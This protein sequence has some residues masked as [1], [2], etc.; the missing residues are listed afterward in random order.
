MTLP[1]G[2]VIVT[3]MLVGSVKHAWFEIYT[4]C[5]EK[6][7]NSLIGA[8]WSPEDAAKLTIDAME[9]TNDEASYFKNKLKFLE[10][11]Q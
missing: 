6:V 1:V 4:P 3:L 7:F 11:G 8:E 9:M 2:S 5:D 10:G